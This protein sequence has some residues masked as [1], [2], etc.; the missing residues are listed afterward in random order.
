[1]AAPGDG[2]S[3]DGFGV[4]STLPANLGTFWNGSRSR[5][6]V[7]GGARYGY[8][9]G[10][11]FAAPIAAGIA[12]LTWQ[13]ERRLASDQVAAVLARSAR[14]T[15]GRGWN[16]FTG[17]GIVDGAAAAALARVY[18]VTAPRARG[19]ARRLGAS[20]RVRQRR[21]RDRTERGRRLAGGVRY[22][23]LVSRNG[24]RSF[25]PVGP[26][27][28]SP[29]STTVPLRGRRANVLAAIACDRNGNCGVKRLGRYRR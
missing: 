11:S 24:G 23:L 2:P 26:R 9:E 5:I 4:F 16:E 15:I 21:S 19:T 12:A 17:A 14:Q 1:L 7:A 28:R 10:T 22:R 27:Q 20:V 25:S 13:V 29:I 8:A 6:L 18:D 3:G